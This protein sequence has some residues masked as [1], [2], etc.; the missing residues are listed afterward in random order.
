MWSLEE[1][2]K[3]YSSCFSEKTKV[4]L[5]TGVFIIS[6]TNKILME[7]RSDCGWWG[8]P[9]GKIEVG[10]TASEAIIR[11][12]KEETSINLNKDNL[13]LMGVY[14]NPTEGRIL[15]YPD[16][17]VHLIDIIFSINLNKK[18]S[19]ILSEESLEMKFFSRKMLSEEKYLVPPCVK[20]IND[21]L[22]L[23]QKNAPFIR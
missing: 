15:T 19:I 1:I 16:Q 17:Q 23:D 14:S 10:E 20:P 18:Y 12:I 4:R 2:K 21:W 9:G 13:K 8:I 7:K 22:N 3:R 11:E 5:G 6:K